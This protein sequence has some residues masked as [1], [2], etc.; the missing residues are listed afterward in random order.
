MKHILFIVLLSPVFLFAQSFPTDVKVISDVKTYHGKIATA[1]VQNEWKLEKEPGYQFA[2]MAKRVVAA[3][4]VKENGVSKKIIGLAI[5][6][7]GSAGEAWKFSRYFVTGSEVVGAKTLTSEDLKQQTLD[8]IRKEPIK[9][10]VDF[11]DVSWVYDI[12]FPD[13][14]QN[15]TDR[16]GDVIYNGF[17][18]Y[19]RK[20]NDSEGITLP[21]Y[22]F[23]AGLKRFRAQ[24][25]A[26]VRLVDGQMKVA[27]VSVG[28]AE[29]TD[30]KMLSRKTFESLPSLANTSIDQLFGPVCPYLNADTEKEGKSS[31]PSSSS[32]E[33]KTKK[34]GLPKI[35]I[36]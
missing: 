30:K 23:E 11:K 17:I 6:V 36:Q 18:E 2:N 4:T 20:W 14:S 13:V 15:R 33:K 9:V 19:E 16:T 1:S 32:T 27:V 12:T 3:T 24:V 8:L 31:E 29:S 22:P 5:Y 25:E 21:N 34:I 7:R 35:K 10:F 26:Y 28:Y